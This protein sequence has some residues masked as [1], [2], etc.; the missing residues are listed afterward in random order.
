MGGYGWFGG[1]ERHLRQSA[2]VALDPDQRTLSR[3][4]VQTAGLLCVRV[5]DEMFL[6]AATALAAQV[7]VQVFRHHFDR[8]GRSPSGRS[9]W[10]HGGALRSVR[11]RTRAGRIKQTVL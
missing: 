8:V 10:N 11:Q 2:A 9:A 6:A 3:P 7:T 5:T 4:S 1:G